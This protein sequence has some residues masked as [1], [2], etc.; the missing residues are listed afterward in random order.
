MCKIFEKSHEKSQE[1][2]HVLRTK[3][4]LGNA[5]GVLEGLINRGFFCF[6]IFTPSSVQCTLQVTHGLGE[7]DIQTS[8][9]NLVN[10]ESA[11]SL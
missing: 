2:N 3:L 6:F 4:L 10:P 5:L 1:L 8:K 9:N 11:L 7:E